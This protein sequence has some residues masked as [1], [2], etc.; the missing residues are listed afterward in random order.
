[1]V[2]VF[3][4]NTP[5][6]GG[7]HRHEGSWILYNFSEDRYSFYINGR[8]GR[9]GFV[10][11]KKQ[12]NSGTRLTVSVSPTGLLSFELEGT[13]LHTFQLPDI[14]DLYAAVEMCKL[15]HMATFI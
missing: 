2:G 6:N 13:L 12:Y 15:G 10:D 4:G 8:N 14:V 9:Y 7:I 5:T 1:M 3:K 11:T